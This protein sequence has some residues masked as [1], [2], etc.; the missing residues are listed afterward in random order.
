MVIYGV[1]VY[2]M[3]CSMNLIALIMK[4]KVEIILEM[5]VIQIYCF[6]NKRRE[7]SSVTS[8]R[9][10]R[11]STEK[12]RICKIPGKPNFLCGGLLWAI[13]S[14]PTGG[15]KGTTPWLQI[16]K[17][18]SKITS[19]E[20]P[21]IMTFSDNSNGLAYTIMCTCTSIKQ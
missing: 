5:I 3:T 8:M 17:S 14:I 7:N 20:S 19:R 18:K 11:G 9:T 4:I 10:W 21:F 16:Q 1:L 2:L 15:N 6:Y 13:I 12:N